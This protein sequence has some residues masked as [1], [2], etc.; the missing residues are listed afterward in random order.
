[1]TVLATINESLTVMCTYACHHSSLELGSEGKKKFYLG[2]FQ[3]VETKGD[4]WVT[5]QEFGSFKKSLLKVPT[6]LP[7]ICARPQKALHI[8][9]FIYLN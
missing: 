6:F 4:Q 5:K 2:F 8:Y 7:S 3:E 1:M 9:I